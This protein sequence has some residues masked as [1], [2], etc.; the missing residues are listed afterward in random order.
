MKLFKASLI[1]L[2]LASA[3]FANAASLAITNAKVH[4]QTA[5][6]VLDNATIIIED[7][8]IS[9]INP[10]SISAD[11]TLDAQGKVLTPGFINSLNTLGLVE[12][13][14]VKRSQDAHDDDATITFDPSTAFN[15]KSSLIPLMRKGGIT[16]NVTMP[17]GGKDM[18]KGLLFAADTSGQFD[19]LV[20]TRLGVLVELGAES[21]GSRAMSLQ[22][23][24]EKLTDANKALAKAKKDQ[25]KDKKEPKRDE[26]IL[27]RLV[28]GEQKLIAYVDRAT[29]ILALLKLKQQFNL[30]LILASADDA[31]LVTEQIVAAKVPVIVNADAN[32][33]EGF[34]SLHTSLS[35]P[36]KL[37]KAGVQVV[38]MTS[39]DTHM[40]YE[41]RHQ[42]GIAVAHGMDYQSA[43]AAVTKNP[44][45]VFG[46]SELGT[47]A[48]GQQADLVLWSAD[49]FE[50]STKVEQ[51]WIQGQAHSTESRIDKLRDRYMAESELPRAYIK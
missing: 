12:V 41:L 31:I 25:A 29:D 10:T 51:L 30:D 38:L 40:G 32:L 46:L 18:F 50:L 27:Q 23:L 7:G 1:A 49:P 11:S 16:S 45:Q 2:G 17:H 35:N 33:P 3:G 21:K 4:T 44:A 43:L 39:G 34:D 26:L 6:G 37:A 8:K 5:Q 20:E 28:K 36:G 48:V 14:A 47:I 22:K 9:A 19:S 42:A 15:P 24:T 13:S